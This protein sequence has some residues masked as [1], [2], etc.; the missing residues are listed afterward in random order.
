MSEVVDFFR[1]TY[2]PTILSSIK[3]TDEFIRR[4]QNIIDLRSFVLLAKFVIVSLCP[5]IPHD[6]GLCARMDFPLDR[7]LSTIVVDGI[8]NMTEMVL[9]KECLNLTLNV[10]FKFLT[11]Q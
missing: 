2:L 9:K 7:N 11:Q 10:S 1:R 5:G 4:I 3:D 6:F 8:H